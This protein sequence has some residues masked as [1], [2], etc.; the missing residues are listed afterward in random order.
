MPTKTADLRPARERLLAAANEL[1]Y[2]EGV[3]TVGIDRV[4]ERAGVAKATL[5]STFGSK[6]ELIRE[7]LHGRH[8]A[9]RERIVAALERYSAPRDRLLG[10]FDVLGDS[11]AEPGFHGCAFLNASAEAQ[12][13]SSIIEATDEYRSWVRGLFTDLAREA[14]ASDPDGL[15]RALH[16]LYDGAGV[17]A[18]MDRDLG[19]AAAARAVAVVLLDAAV[20]G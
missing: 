4:I 6:D 14:G 8:V 18:R 1:F 13:G 16:L 17:S 2:E 10:V 7:Y 19:A 20:T 5:Y 15:A 3:H 11:F 9:R 12:P